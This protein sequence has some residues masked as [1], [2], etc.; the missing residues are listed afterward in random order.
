MQTV[1][2][3][4]QNK[5]IEEQNQLEEV[6]EVEEA[7]QSEQTNGTEENKQ[8]QES[9]PKNPKFIK[10]G[11]G[12]FLTQVN[13][14]DELY[15]IWL[16]NPC[17]VLANYEN[18]ETGLEQVEVC[19][20]PTG[21]DAEYK[22]MSF[23]A[24]TFS[25]ERCLEKLLEYGFCFNPE[26]KKHLIEYFNNERQQARRA[27]QHTG[28]GFA[29]ADGTSYFKHYQTIG[30]DREST[31]VGPF[32]IEPHG[33]YEAWLSMVKAEVLPNPAL[34]LGLILG[35]LAPVVGFIGRELALESQFYHIYGDSSS[36]KSSVCQ[37]IASTFG[38]S[39]LQNGGLFRS[40]YATETAIYCLLASNRGVPIIFD[41]ASLSGKKN[42]TNLVYGLSSGNDK[43]RVNANLELRKMD[44]F[45]TCI[46]SN[47]EYS[48]LEKTDNV[49][50]PKARLIE[51]TDIIWTADA[52]QSD[53]IKKCTMSNYGH[54]GIHFVE[55]LLLIGKAK[56]IH[57]FEKEMIRLSNSLPKSQIS[58]RLIKKFALFTTTMK[59]VSYS[60]NLTLMD[61][62]VEE[63]FLQQITVNNDESDLA[64]KAFYA[65]NQFIIDHLD[66]FDLKFK[67]IGGSGWQYDKA[68][69]SCYGQLVYSDTTKQS[70]KEVV[71]STHIINQTLEKYYRFHSG[72][73]VMNQFKNRGW[74]SCEQD[75]TYRK[76][77]INGN[78]IP[79]YV[80]DIP[81]IYEFLKVE[82]DSTLKVERSKRRE[83]VPLEE[84]GA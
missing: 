12:I 7:N 39:H 22:T 82:D 17:H 33:S 11:N 65:I 13:K 60:F 35:F 19:F 84:I 25:S 59:L 55:R 43:T 61:K 47:G 26:E 38:S 66:K 56:V 36:G 34:Q 27:L 75:K 57:Y 3:L 10:T 50:G 71:V 48:L 78:Q 21:R 53:R 45:L 69:G 81:K 52:A 58:E 49:N 9:V 37:L 63:L 77:K 64:V 68:Q 74:L 72:S 40:W 8:L 42:Y 62:E 79:V 24:Q 15:Y 54:A 4:E 1:S 16:A 23:D 70:L 18:L 28:L 76:R 51:F 67:A 46:I 80:I 31:Y 41:E 6:N 32:N 14:E 20:R 29:E 44:S 73:G 83:Y 2:Q 30:F 5:V